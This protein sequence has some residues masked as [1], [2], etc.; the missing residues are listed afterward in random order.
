MR[1]PHNLVAQQAQRSWGGSG[2]SGLWSHTG[3]QLRCGDDRGLGDCARPGG[4]SQD[5]GSLWGIFPRGGRHLPLC[6][7]GTLGRGQERGA[8]EEPPPWSWER[9]SGRRRRAGRASSAEVRGDKARDPCPGRAR[10]C[11]ESG[12]PVLLQRAEPRRPPGQEWE[13]P[14][15]SSVSEIRRTWGQLGGSGLRWTS[16]LYYDTLGTRGATCSRLPG[17]GLPWTSSPLGPAHHAGHTRLQGLLGT[18]LPQCRCGRGRAGSPSAHSRPRSAR[19]RR[20][21][22]QGQPRAQHGPFWSR[23]L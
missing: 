2:P 9:E 4:T 14:G 17:E 10:A 23:G 20:T 13:G 22:L 6:G 8:Q 7:G 19:G 16:A 18:I 5:R 21:C 12:V 15:A 3:R 1:R 11:L